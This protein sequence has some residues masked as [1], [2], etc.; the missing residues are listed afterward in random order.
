MGHD[1]I[2]TFSCPDRPGLAYAVA[3]FVLEHSG[4]VLESQQYNDTVTDRFF[5]RVEFSAP[6]TATG[7]ASANAPHRRCEARF[8][9]VRRA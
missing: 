6:D 3:G 2:L 7:T 9:A 8:R 4:N 1:L 5:M